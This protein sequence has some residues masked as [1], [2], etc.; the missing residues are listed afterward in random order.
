MSTGGGEG[1]RIFVALIGGEGGFWAQVGLVQTHLRSGAGD[2]TVAVG[3]NITAL[4]TSVSGPLTRTGVI[5]GKQITGCAS[6]RTSNI[7][8]FTHV[9]VTCRHLFK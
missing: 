7:D 9:N 3:E 6:K 1:S 4:S 2:I 8:F 5:I